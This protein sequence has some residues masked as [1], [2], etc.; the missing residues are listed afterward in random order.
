MISLQIKL[1]QQFTV[2]I[3]LI[4][5][6]LNM[7]LMIFMTH[8]LNILLL[9]LF[10]K[11]WIVIWNQFFLI[12]AIIH[13]IHHYLLVDKELQKRILMAMQYLIS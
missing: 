6:L 2:E 4:S 11:T 12:L 1:T 5:L 13:L 8:Y 7:N 3:F 9:P 10:Q